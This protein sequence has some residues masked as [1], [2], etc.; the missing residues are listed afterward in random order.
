MIARIHTTALMPP[1][2]PGA[3]G[4]AVLTRVLAD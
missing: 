4:S 3:A 2:T 1:R